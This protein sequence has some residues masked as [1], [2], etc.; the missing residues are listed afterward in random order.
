MTPDARLQIAQATIDAARRKFVDEPEREEQQRK[1]VPETLECRAMEARK[2]L[3]KPREARAAVVILSVL[4]LCVGAG[5]LFW[6]IGSGGASAK[7]GS[8]TRTFPKVV[9]VKSK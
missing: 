7:Q 2:L 5:M 1:P 6:L 9:E 3:E 4:A 8:E